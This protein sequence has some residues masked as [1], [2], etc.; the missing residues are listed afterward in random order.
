ME[1]VSRLKP[2]PGEKMTPPTRVTAVEE[3]EAVRSWIYFP[4]SMDV[5]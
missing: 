2:Y 1:T 4:N 5:D 3:E